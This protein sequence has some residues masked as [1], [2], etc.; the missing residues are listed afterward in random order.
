MSE[1]C[2]SCGK[3][4]T[5]KGEKGDTGPTGPQGPAGTATT[6]VIDMNTGVV[7]LLPADTGSRVLMSG[8][9]SATLPTDPPVGTNYTFTTV[10]DLSSGVFSIAATGGNIMS[11]YVYANSSAAATEIFKPIAA[12]NTITLD[13]GATGGNVGTNITTTYVGSSMW[14][15]SGTTMSDAAVLT[16]PFS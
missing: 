8:P 16:T 12:N 15:V 6:P 5:P 9:S 2:S 11:G 3:V 14:T 4:I 1:T 13:G 7:A 10:T